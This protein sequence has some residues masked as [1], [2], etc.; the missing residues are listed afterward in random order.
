ML[1]VLTV[2][3]HDTEL[4]IPADVSFRIARVADRRCP[5]GQLCIIQGERWLDLLKIQRA[6][7]AN[8][9]AHCGPSQK[10]CLR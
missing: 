10:D 6:K 5:D 9:K 7:K 3:L 4:P 2:G 8:K 1:E